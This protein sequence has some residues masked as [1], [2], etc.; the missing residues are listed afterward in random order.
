MS[1]PESYAIA[2]TPEQAL[3]RA[4]RSRSRVSL[5]LFWWQLAGISGFTSAKAVSREF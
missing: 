4:R 2:D 5:V 1:E 3:P